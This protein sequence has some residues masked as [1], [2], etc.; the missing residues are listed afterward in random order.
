MFQFHFVYLSAA[1]ATGFRNFGDCAAFTD[2]IRKTCAE[3]TSPTKQLDF[4]LR[5]NVSRCQNEARIRVLLKDGDCSDKNQVNIQIIRT[6][7]QKHD[8]CLW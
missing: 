7:I 5:A 2:R 8:L 1:I 3:M 6:K 4:V